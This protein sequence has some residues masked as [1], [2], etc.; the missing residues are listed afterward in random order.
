MADNTNKTDKKTND[1][2]GTEYC[3][4][5]LNKIVDTDRLIEVRNTMPPPGNPNR[6]KDNKDNES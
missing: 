2:S 6:D 3:H 5:D 1:S 4:V